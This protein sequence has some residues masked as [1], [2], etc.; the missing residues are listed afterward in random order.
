MEDGS[1]EDRL[2]KHLGTPGLDIARQAYQWA[3]N[4]KPKTFDNEHDFNVYVV[5][6]IN[7]MLKSGVWVDF[8]KNKEHE[9]RGKTKM[10]DPAWTTPFPN[11]KK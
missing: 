7:Q 5:E 10:S 11:K 1:L 4:H 8:R 9:L 6:F 2:Y 3:E